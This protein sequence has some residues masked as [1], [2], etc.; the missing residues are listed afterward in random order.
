MKTLE[1][2]AGVIKSSTTIRGL[3]TRVKDKLVVEHKS[4]RSPALVAVIIS[5][6]QKIRNKA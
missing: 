6:K 5:V 2:C 3:L 4:S 1:E